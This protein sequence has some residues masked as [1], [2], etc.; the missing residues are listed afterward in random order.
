MMNSETTRLAVSP[1]A[2]MVIL[3]AFGSPLSAQDE[4]ISRQISSIPRTSSDEVM[5]RSTELTDEA[6]F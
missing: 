2:L 6:G 5:Q 4:T 1:I 3:F